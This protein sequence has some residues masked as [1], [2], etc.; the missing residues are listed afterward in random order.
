MVALAFALRSILPV[1]CFAFHSSWCPIYES[2]VSKKPVVRYEITSHILTPCLGFFL[3][4]PTNMFKL[5]IHL[6]QL[7]SVSFPHFCS[8]LFSIF[9]SEMCPCFCSVLRVI[10]FCLVIFPNFCSESFPA[11]VLRTFFGAPLSRRIF[12]LM[13]RKDCLR[14]LGMSLDD[15]ILEK[16]RGMNQPI[17][18]TWS[19]VN[20]HRVNYCM[21]YIVSIKIVCSSSLYPA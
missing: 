10:Y 20:I 1:I 15:Y 18:H 8:Q 5:H 6:L 17:Q 16:L 21:S 19:L 7:Y 3:A 13:I 11:S 12:L 4:A 14:E 2:R 9:C